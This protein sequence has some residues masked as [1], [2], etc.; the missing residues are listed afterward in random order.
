MR[1]AWAIPAGVFLLD[2]ITKLAA[3]SLPSEGIIPV[4]GVI[5]LKLT[6]N[7][8]IAFSLFSGN[9][10]L[11]GMISLAV[12]ILGFWLFRKKKIGGVGLAGLLLMM[13]G[14]LGNVP[15][16]LIAGAVPDMIEFLFVRFAVFNVADIALT[17]G[18]GL[19]AIS[20]LFRPEDWEG[21]KDGKPDGGKDPDGGR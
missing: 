12:V 7:E 8:G 18:C 21:A 1:K 15:D 10:R 11:L 4:P 5:R 3:R 9:G 16:R 2:R 13:G 19:T 6:E 20:L 17:V 14:A